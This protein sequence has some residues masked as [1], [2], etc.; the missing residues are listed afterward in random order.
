MGDAS[1]NHR[2]RGNPYRRLTLGLLGASLFIL[3][4]FA[5]FNT[6]I[7]PLWVTPTPWTDESFA[8]HRQIYSSIRTAKAGLA[9][10]L[11][12]DV[13]FV[14][15]SRVAI[16]LDPANPNLGD[17][18]AVNLGISGGAVTENGP[19][20]QYVLDHQPEIQKI[21]LGLDLTDLTSDTDLSRNA[22]FYESPFNE[23]GDSFER[24]LRYVVGFSSAEASWK[25]LRART[26]GQ[27][28]PYTALGHWARF[29][30]VDPVR[31][32]L[33]RDS[34]PFAMRYARLRKSQL[35]LSERKVAA[36]REAVRAC[37]KRSV[38]LV[39]AIPP[40][41]AAYLCV[42]PLAGDPD[43]YFMIDRKA[44]AEVIAE[45]NANFPDSPPVVLW[46]FNSYHP[47]NSE[48][49]PPDGT[50]AKYWVDGT[51]AL[52]TLGDVMLARIHG[53]PLED[54]EEQSYGRILTPE[55]IDE[56][57]AEIDAGYQRYQTEHRDDWLWVQKVMG[58]YDSTDAPST[59]PALPQ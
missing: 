18:R 37:L 14:G 5:A 17:L 43:P 56:R 59:P 13:T 8:E 26:T 10:S 23:Q 20:S 42:F 1:S 36:L 53:W 32:I 48:S 49:I 38:E 54:P 41:H 27:P 44:A 28:T 50:P 31:T 29:R 2:R 30:S 16:A 58:E 57:E 21:I 4:V 15:S 45:E 35:A 7:N 52:E 47:L 33:R 55:V 9:R 39:V 22:G 12:W 11:E 51:H 24:E 6:W 3:A 19:I 34:V 46:D 40:N 25:T